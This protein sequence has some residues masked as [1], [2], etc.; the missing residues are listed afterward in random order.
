MQQRS[1]T[2]ISVNFAFFK[3]YLSVLLNIVLFVVSFMKGFKRK[4]HPSQLTH[5]RTHSKFPLIETFLETLMDSSKQVM[6]V[7]QYIIR[8]TCTFSV[9]SLG[10]ICN[11]SDHGTSKEVQ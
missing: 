7:V 2:M 6:Y 5:L 8:C 11:H 4:G 3:F 10:V 9:P 1:Q